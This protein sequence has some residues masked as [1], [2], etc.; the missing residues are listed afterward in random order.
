MRHHR[1]ALTVLITL[2]LAPGVAQADAWEAP[3][4]RPAS[5]VVVDVAAKARAFWAARGMTTECPQGI[6]VWQAAD[7]IG[8]WGRGDGSTCEVWIA[9]DAADRLRFGTSM[10]RFDLIDV[11]TAITH[12]TGH[13]LGLGH[14][15]TGVMA[16]GDSRPTQPR[17]W[18]P[19]FCRGWAD[20]RMD[21]QH[22]LDGVTESQVKRWHRHRR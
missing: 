14:T 21:V 11:C 5:P 20:E 16:G 18:A 4:Q 1:T 8:A 3:D 2:A 22:R 9:D 6:T 19:F 13:A 17:A 12:E 10:T 15:P 7:L